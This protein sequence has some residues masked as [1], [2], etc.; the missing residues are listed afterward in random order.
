M[1]LLIHDEE[2]DQD[3]MEGGDEC[4][5]YNVLSPLEELDTISQNSC[6]E[7]TFVADVLSSVKYQAS[8]EILEKVA[9][10]CRKG[11]RIH[12]SILDAKT[13]CTAIS[14]NVAEVERLNEIVQTVKSVQN[15][16]DIYS[17]FKE[18]NITVFSAKKDG[19][20]IVLK[21]VRN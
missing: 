5:K 14:T 6:K 19:L 21:A 11:G 2:V 12:L 15:V 9:T 17:V 4:I 20:R 1:K 10:K 13:I 3:A 16:D 8:R 7:I 18:N